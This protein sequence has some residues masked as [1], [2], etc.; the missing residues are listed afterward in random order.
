MNATDPAAHIDV[1]DVDGGAG[2]LV[3]FRDAFLNYATSERLAT[4]LKTLCRE[5]SAG[6][7]RWFVVDLSS[8][9]VMDSCGLSM[10][11]AMKRTAEAGGARLRLF[12]LSE[13]IRKLFEVTKIERVF[14]ICADERA[15]LAPLVGDA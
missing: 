5:R 1:T 10:L 9:V 15:A 12:G 7:V 4:D 6:G 2:V 11:V 3:R 14:D 13:T 8:V